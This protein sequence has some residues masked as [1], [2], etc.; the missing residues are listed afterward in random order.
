MFIF[1][2]KIKFSYHIDV[3]TTATGWM[4]KE[5]WFDFRQGQGFSIFFKCFGQLRVPTQLPLQRTS[6]DFSR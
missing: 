1:C 5:S 4:T 2:E 6:E 3:M